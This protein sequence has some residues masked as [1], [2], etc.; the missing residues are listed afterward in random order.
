MSTN[1]ERNLNASASAIYNK[2]RKLGLITFPMTISENK[3]GKKQ[4]SNMPTNI[5]S[6]SKSIIDKNFNGCMARMGTVI[7]GS[8]EKELFV[9]GLDID[10]KP[11][12]T[13]I[14]NGLTKWTN[15]L[16]EHG[17]THFQDINTPTQLTGNQGYHYL[18]AVSEEQLEH[19]GCSLTN[20]KIDGMT[21]SI[22]VKAKNQMLIVEPSTYNKKTYKWLKQPSDIPIMILPD[23]LYDIILSNK[24]S[25]KVIK[26][27]VKSTN[28]KIAIETITNLPHIMDEDTINLLECID[29]KRYLTYSKWI[30]LGHLFYSLD[31]DLNY[32]ISKSQS[33]P[34]YKVG[35]CAYKWTTFKNKK[36]KLGTLHY[37]AKADNPEKY[38]NIVF[39]NNK[40]NSTDNFMNIQSYEQTKINTKYLLDDKKGLSD[41]DN[42][43]TSLLDDFYNYDN[44]KSFNIK[45]AY[46]T[47]KTQLIKQ[48][49]TKY[50]PK[51]ILWITYR[52]TLTNNIFGEFSSFNFKSYMDGGYDSD[53]FICQTESLTHIRN[54]DDLFIDDDRCMIPTYDLVIID[55][56]EG[57]LNHF[58]SDT[59]KG[60]GKDVFDYMSDIIRYSKK[61]ITLDGDMS[62]RALEFIQPFGEMK[63][64]NNEYNENP[65]TFSIINQQDMFNK[66][67]I[68]SLDEAIKLNRKI[69]ICSMSKDKTSEY[70]KLIL[71]HNKDVRILVINSD[72]SDEDK[73]MLKNIA[74]EILKY[75]VFIY[76]PSVEAGVNIDVRD[77][78]Y[79]LFGIFSDRSTSPRAFC[80]MMA[81]IRHLDDNNISI[82]NTVFKLYK[83]SP[84][85]WKFQEVEGALKQLKELHYNRTVEIIDGQPAEQ[86]LINSYDINYIHNKLEKLN[87]NKYYFLAVLQM[88]CKSKGIQFIMTNEK[89]SVNKIQKIKPDT[90]FLNSKI[91]NSNDIVFNSIQYDELYHK[92]KTNQATTTEK[93]QLKKADIKMLLGVSQLDDAI[94]NKYK[95]NY[96]MTNSFINL[97]DEDNIRVHT[98]GKH[99]EKRERAKITL[100]LIKDIGFDNI[101]DDKI[102]DVETFDKNIE[103]I[104]KTNPI[105]KSVKE[106]QVLFNL[107]KIKPNVSTKKAI[108][109][110]LGSILNYSNLSICSSRKKVRGNQITSYTLIR[111]N[112]VCEIIKMK[113]DNGFRFKDTQ[114]L[115]QCVEP[116]EWNYL[117]ELKNNN[118]IEAIEATVNNV[119][120]VE[121]YN[122][123][124]E[125]CFTLKFDDE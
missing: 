111:L 97:L 6:M 106:T 74:T 72:T 70:E 26:H 30:Q 94:L 12:T 7:K 84:I 66:E 112:N 81:R 105:Y 38:N 78:F 122:E 57:I 61:V 103:H 115:F 15:L 32:W 49:I 25:K 4:L 83:N 69:G 27:E 68:L 124:V 89:D 2:Y 86:F 41:N 93:L 80:Q 10:N 54:N 14:W 90:H 19:I 110:Y 56:I 16:L 79:K 71:D 87:K 108:L 5:N 92:R 50:E 76:S 114:N 35:E 40:S 44:Y 121:K 33:S 85:M 91:I 113:Q 17:F 109:G 77:C 96:D 99:I 43:L 65:R 42:I 95:G 31:I 120:S 100:A 98:D 58:S 125:C 53:R 29:N 3:Q 18:F 67:L 48:I 11:D 119:V 46:G 55:E 88:Y 75:D 23:W 59:F 101:F 34:N 62:K 64:V 104:I 123:I 45:S 9:V 73:R 116:F 8:N 102:I 52:Q 117:N 118:A 24:P 21:Y 82:L 37:I 22:D 20:L 47:G 107:A 28:L 13:D 60:K 51:K 63:I 39:L 36:Y 1:R